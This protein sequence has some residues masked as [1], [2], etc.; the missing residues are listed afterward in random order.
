M[1]TLKLKERVNSLS[2]RLG[3]SREKEM[4]CL[5]AIEK[6]VGRL[7]EYR[8]ADYVAELRGEHSTH[9][10][11]IFNEEQNLNMYRTNLEVT[12]A[13]INSFMEELEWLEEFVEA[14]HAAASRED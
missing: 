10:T 2:D 1:Y 6:T 9:S 11:S 8:T 4:E 12:R 3:F 14:E 7:R 13:W 5:V